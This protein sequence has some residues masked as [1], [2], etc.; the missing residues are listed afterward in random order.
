MLEQNLKNIHLI[1]PSL[2]GRL[3]LGALNIVSFVHLI[4]PNLGQ[5]VSLEEYKYYGIEVLCQVLG[6]LQMCKYIFKN[7]EIC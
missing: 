3:R 7:S 6:P 1:Q 2:L 4:D 5:S